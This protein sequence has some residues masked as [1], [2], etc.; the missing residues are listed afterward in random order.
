VVTGGVIKTVFRHV[1]VFLAEL[2]QA[3]EAAFTL[4]LL[5]LV[6]IAGRLGLINVEEDFFRGEGTEALLHRLQNL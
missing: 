5:Q 1:T 6:L 3:P 4:E 2:G